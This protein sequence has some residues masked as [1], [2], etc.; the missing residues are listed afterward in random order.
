[1]K[2]AIR[3]TGFGIA[4]AIFCLSA[5]VSPGSALSTSVPYTTATPAASA[6][7]I[8]TYAG[9]TFSGDGGPATAAFL[10]SIDGIASDPQGNLYLADSSD[11]RVRMVQPNG[12]ITTVAGD[13]MPGFSGD[14]SVALLARLKS[15][16]GLATD[17]FGNLFIADFG[18]G[19]VRK[20]S[21]DGRITTV[22]GGLAG[23]RNLVVDLIGNLYISDA[24]ANRVYMLSAA[25]KLNLI[26]GDGT[27]IAL[28][29]PAGLA[30]DYLGTL[31]IADTGTQ[32]IIRLAA[33]KA[34]TLSNQPPLSGT[35]LA[36]AS[37]YYGRLLI[38]TAEGGLLARNLDG[39]LTPLLPSHTFKTLRALHQD[40]AG[41]VY[42]SE[43]SRVWRVASLGSVAVL[44]GHGDS[45]SP[46]PATATEARLSAPM[47]VAIEPT[48]NLYFA[49]EQARRV[50]RVNASGSLQLIAGTG[51]APSS[52]MAAGDG[53]PATS[54][55]LFDPVAIAVSPLG[56]IAIAEF[57]AHRVRIVLPNGIIFTAAGTGSPGI[58]GDNGPAQ[59]AQLN[60]PRGLAYDPAGNLYIADSGNGL[61]RKLGR[62]GFLT[63][64]GT[65]ALDNPTS[66]AIDPNGLIFVA[67]SGKNAIRRLS[68]ANTWDPVTQ[69]QF[70]FPSGLAFDSN[71]HLYIADV[72]NHTIR[73][74]N[75]AGLIET[76]AGTGTAAMGA[77]GAP[78]LQAQLNSPVALA[79]DAQGRVFV[80]DLDNR[81]IR[82]LT[83]EAVAPPPVHVE[84]LAQ[85]ETPIRVLHS[86]T[87]KEGLYAPGQLVS[88]FGTGLAQAAE[89]RIN[90]KP[91]MLSY[92]SDTQINFQLPYLTAPDALIEVIAAAAVIAHSTIPL[93]PSA[94][95]L[96]GPLPSAS[97][98]AIASFY[99]TGGG[100][101]DPEGKPRLPVSLH[102]GNVPVDLLYV[103]EAANAPG[104]LQL[105]VQLP[106]MFTAPG[107][108]PVTLT[109]G[110][111]S[112]PSGTTI[113]LQ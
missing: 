31:F 71:G 112:S 1:M 45:A 2:I 113:N 42:F 43:P 64:L 56:E 99:A 20:L 77:E 59:F 8:T 40:L 102:I 27:P 63:T 106:G 109:I 23:P 52:P 68:L 66:I 7:R 19:R 22:A 18:N 14:N 32:S 83:P 57:A 47:S 73:R 89:V 24:P 84:P 101:L 39:A 85:S 76:I 103:G 11:H 29:F 51:A 94:P 72:Y 91:A 80:A 111:N 28:K 33:G 87:L 36:L 35:P 48:G 81:R 49:D 6:Y 104:V 16:Y 5:Q 105:N 61:V 69:G 75:P 93:S 50:W 37:D 86:A 100:L 55:P 88:L 4:T 30:V 110:P 65:G 15:P 98:G 97:R 74:I 79:V 82:L 95:G 13:G 58:A 12:R 26:A 25:G 96:F 21:R 9:G 38:A 108:H 70:N 41:T 78:A 60:K 107:A 62:N 17:T 92:A 34:G 67:E 90:G 53:G 54:A 46:I 44:A 3:L 10:G